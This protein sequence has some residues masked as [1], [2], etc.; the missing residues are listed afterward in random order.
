MRT[1]AGEGVEEDRTDFT[2]FTRRYE[3]Y[4]GWGGVEEDRTEFTTSTRRCEA[5]R[6]WGG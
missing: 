4:R 5:Y 3:A 2:T 6:D 1:E